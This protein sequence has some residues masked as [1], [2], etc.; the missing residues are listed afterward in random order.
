MAGPTP[1][2]C[3]SR[4]PSSPRAICRLRAYALLELSAASERDDALEGLV[5]YCLGEASLVW[6]GLLGP[7]QIEW[8]HRVRDD[9]ESYRAAK[10]AAA[11]AAPASDVE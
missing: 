3:T 8:L 9:L 5:R 10:A 6:E 2:C 1:T 11:A 4:L 7:A